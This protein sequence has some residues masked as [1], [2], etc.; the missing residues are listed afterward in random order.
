MNITVTWSAVADPS[1][2]E[3][4]VFTLEVDGVVIESSMF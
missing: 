4:N 1:G 3:W 2:C